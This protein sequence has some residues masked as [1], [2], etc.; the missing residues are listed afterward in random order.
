M[1]P[2]FGAAAGSIAVLPLAFILTVTAIKDGV[3]DYRRGSLDDQ[4][5][6]SAATK[7]GGGWRNVNQPTDPRSWLEKLLGINPPGKVTKGVRKLR[8]REAGEGMRVVLSR[9]GEAGDV[10]SVLTH[11]VSQSSLDLRGGAGGRRL[12]DIQSVDSHS[13]PPTTV[14]ALS[15]TSL[16][17]GSVKQSTEWAQFGSLAQYQQSIQSQSSVGVV[18]WNKHAGGSS[19]WERTL[20]KKLEVGDIVLLRD[21]DQVP[22]DIV[23]LSTSDPE[24]MCYL[25]TKNLDGETNLKPRKAVKGTSTIASEEDIE[26]SSFYLDSEPPHQNLYQYHGVLRYDDPTSGEQRQEPVTI[27][28]LLL[29]GC[30][31]RNTGWV[32]GLVVFTGADTK[33]M[34]N[35][36]DT[37]SKRSKIEKETNFNV[38]VNF[39]LL[40]IMC[41]VS[42][43]FSGLEDARTGTSAEF[44][45]I[46]ADPTTSHV[47]NAII[48]FV[49]VP[50]CCHSLFTKHDATKGHV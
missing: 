28:E 14:G 4:V 40:S 2:V 23:V 33:I 35:G 41:L 49:Y 46:G 47:I 21:N 9:G 5:N 3:E 34:L 17:E 29:R 18:N 38:I 20:W 26:R 44:Y 50:L 31:L 39:G 1:F 48:T 16:S 25:E 6:N 43:I 7:L 13:Y 15:K 37:P 27:N 22:A 32:I 12:E 8:D 24:G 36:G 30:A 42:A 45:E 19:R 11:D 10:S